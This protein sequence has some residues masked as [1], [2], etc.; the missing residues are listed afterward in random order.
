VIQLGFVLS[1]GGTCIEFDVAPPSFA[2][3]R[4]FMKTR[5]GEGDR[6]SATSSS[7]GHVAVSPAHSCRRHG[8]AACSCPAS[9]SSALLVP[10]VLSLFLRQYV[11]A[12]SVHCDIVHT[13]KCLVA[14]HRSMV[15]GRRVPWPWPWHCLG[16]GIGVVRWAH[17][18]ERVCDARSS[19]TVLVSVAAVMIAHI[20]S[21]LCLLLAAC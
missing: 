14:G 3:S 8:L 15:D 1:T 13:A 11:Q 16:D 6:A 12:S 7:V 20:A 18:Q 10:V 5:R 19:T 2:M 17:P 9:R 21:A 4:T